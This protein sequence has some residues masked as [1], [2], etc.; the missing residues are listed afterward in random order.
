MGEG[1]SGV[2]RLADFLVATQKQE[3]SLS[4]RR[5]LAFSNF[6]NSK[7]HVVFQSSTVGELCKQGNPEANGW[8][9][10]ITD[11]NWKR[12]ISGLSYCKGAGWRTG[13][14]FNRIAPPKL[15][16]CLLPC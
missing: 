10:T 16:P 2:K 15:E 11:P 13:Q 9:F 5:I 14:F 6:L 12:R 3:K 4:P 7:C 8:Y 1:R